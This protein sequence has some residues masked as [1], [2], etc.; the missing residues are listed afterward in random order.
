MNSIKG[1]N[2]PKLGFKPLKL[3]DFLY[4]EGP[5]LSHF[6]DENN[7]HEHYFYK[8][9]DSDT[10]CNRWL[11]TK[12]S[13]ETLSRFLNNDISLRQVIS[14]SA[15]VYLLDLDNDLDEKSILVVN[16]QDLPKSYLP[17]D[18]SFY[19]EKHYEKY[20]LSL[21]ESLLNSKDLVF[22][23]VL[24]ELTSIKKQQRETNQLLNVLL[25][26]FYPDEV[27][28]FGQVAETEAS[29]YGKKI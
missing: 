15:F 2:I 7:V 8:W 21:K 6:V 3:G 16:T 10:E 14:Q 17:S 5:L 1:L 22:N 24:D 28:S 18:D 27:A 26:K 23:H 9:S 4:H 13:E 29:A 11:V 12:F 19:N 25:K 20:A